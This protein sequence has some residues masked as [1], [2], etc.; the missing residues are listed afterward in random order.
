MGSDLNLFRSKGSQSG[1]F[2]E[3]YVNFKIEKIKN[4]NQPYF[5]RTEYNALF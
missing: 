5:F 4:Q 3:H 1:T 2:H